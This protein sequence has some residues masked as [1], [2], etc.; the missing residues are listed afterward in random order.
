MM[1]NHCIFLLPPCQMIRSGGVGA[2]STVARVGA[3]VAPFVPLLS[4]YYEPLPLFLFGGV[5][6]L[7]GLL[8]L[9][10]PETLSL[11]LP[12]TVQEAE[13]IGR[14]RPASGKKN[15]STQGQS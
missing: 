8:A 9:C 3:L 13:Q 11:K 10:L 15:N 5:S 7:G 14:R 2:M 12:D 6:L 4:R 1:N